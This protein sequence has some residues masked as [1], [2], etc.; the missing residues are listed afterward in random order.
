MK[1]HF[2][3]RLACGTVGNFPCFIKFWSLYKQLSKKER[4]AFP[5]LVFRCP[6][7]VKEKRLTGI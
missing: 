1:R 3:A 7:T 6:Q 5:Q 2:A 4:L